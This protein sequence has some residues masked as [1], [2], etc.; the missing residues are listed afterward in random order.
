MK[1]LLITAVMFIVSC[2]HHKDVRPNASGLHFIKIATEDKASGYRDASK[3]ANHFCSEEKAGKKAYIVKEQ[4]EYVGD[5]KEE[6][7]KT[8][9]TASKVA[10]GVGGAAW[11]FGGKKES[12]AGG[13]V[14]LGGGV[15]DQVAGKGYAYAM[16]F[17]CK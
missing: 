5:M 15:A 14:G 6:N 12:D 3:Q 11:V 10:K 13:I 2:A 8:V 16:Q 7:Y 17:Q 1:I 4:Y 9:K